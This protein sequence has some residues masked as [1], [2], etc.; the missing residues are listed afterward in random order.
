MNGVAAGIVAGV[1]LLIA[2]VVGVMSA[3]NWGGAQ[4][5]SAQNYTSTQITQAESN[6]TA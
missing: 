6:L 1:L 3:N 4:Q 2:A 5:T